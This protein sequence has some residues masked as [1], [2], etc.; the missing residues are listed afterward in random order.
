MFTL[1]LF[2]IVPTILFTFAV[3][4]IHKDYKGMHEDAHEDK[5]ANDCSSED[6]EFFNEHVNNNLRNN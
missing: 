2:A 4:E 5:P 6:Y 3:C 1:A